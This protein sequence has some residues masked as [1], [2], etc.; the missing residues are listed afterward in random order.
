MSLL[1]G[2]EALALGVG[3]GPQ[4]GG[5]SVPECSHRQAC[6]GWRGPQVTVGGCSSLSPLPHCWDGTYPQPCP[7]SLSWGS[8]LHPGLRSWPQLWG[9]A[10][11]A[12]RGRRKGPGGTTGDPL[13]VVSAAQGHAGGC[14]P[15]LV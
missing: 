14:T 2:R 7:S 6:P 10:R 8:L 15:E 1:P 5:L 12:L 9:R 3:V 13:Q 4:P 11:S